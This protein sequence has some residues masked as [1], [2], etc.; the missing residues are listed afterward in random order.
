MSLLKYFF[1]PSAPSPTQIPRPLKWSFHNNMPFITPE[2]DPDTYITKG[3]DSIPNVYAIINLILQKTS[4]IPYGFYRVRD[5]KA[6]RKYKGHMK[7]KDYVGAA[8]VRHKA[9]EEVDNHPLTQLLENPNEYQGYEE[10]MYQYGGYYLLTGNSYMMTE[11]PGAGVNAAKPT[12]LH[13]MPSP[14]VEII[15]SDRWGE[16]KG[17]R[18]GVFDNVVDADRV[19]HIKTFNPMTS[20]ENPSNGLYGDSPLKA[21][22]TLLGRYASADIAQGAMFTNMGPA[23]ILFDRS[24]TD[25]SQE[26]M[27]AAKDKLL[28]FKSGES[29]AN[30]IIFTS[31]D[32][33]W[34]AL[35]LSP[36]DLNILDA[37]DEML[38]ELCNVYNTPK[39]LFSNDEA[40]YSNKEQAR[41]QLISDAVIP[42]AEKIKNM[43]NRHLVPKFGGGVVM[44]MDYSIFPE[45]QEDLGEKQKWVSQLWELTPNERRELLTLGRADNELLDKIYVPRS[46]V[47][48][49]DLGIESFDIDT[50]QT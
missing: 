26:Q 30:G 20:N 36:V 4:T 23:G 45:I 10:L 49:E 3:W 32:L 41:K 38:T 27:Q 12:E 14:T 16:A 40:K 17:Y 5:Q 19:I 34:Q 44:E 35:G 2:D 24:G 48:L 18:L 42:L 28:S 21:C 39:E 11:V 46:F 1:P 50:D 47:A 8:L 9:M 33:G 43:V 37:K 31:A 29:N 25:M 22:R 6:Y 15:P 13:V 7:N